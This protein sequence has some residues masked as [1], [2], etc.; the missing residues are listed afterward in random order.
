MLERLKALNLDL[1]NI[2]SIIDILIVAFVLYRLALLIRGTRAVQLLKGLVVLLVATALS[3]WLHLYTFHWLLQQVMTALVVALPIVFQPEL[4]RALE[5]L[6]GGRFFAAP[7]IYQGDFDRSRTVSQLVRAA[8]LLS[9]QRT[10]ALIVLE[11]TTGLEEYTDT[12]IKIEGLISAE[13]LM[14]IFVPKTPLHDGAVIVRGDRVAAAACVLPLTESA[15]VARELGTRHRAG[16]GITEVSDALAIIVSEETGAISLAVE[17]VL[18]RNLD[19]AALADR[20]SGALE[21]R[22]GPSL[23]FL[24]QRK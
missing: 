14:N 6:G 12:G 13:L 2:T 5:K 11:R 7:V 22:Q 19:E 18:A 21:P 9:R 10:G 24:W 4:R 8:S 20:L 15:D 16:I 3:S 23:A 17:G 1:F